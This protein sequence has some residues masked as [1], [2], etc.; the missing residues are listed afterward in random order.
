MVNDEMRKLGKTGDPKATKYL[1]LHGVWKIMF[2]KI[3]DKH[4]SP[5]Y[6]FTHLMGSHFV[7]TRTFLLA[8]ISTL[9]LEGE[10]PGIPGAFTA[11]QQVR[12]DP[13]SAGKLA[14]IR[15]SD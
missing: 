8:P 10:G 2:W 3:I 14:N 9:E 13:E 12:L 7:L 15:V 6:L 1:T 11:T 5:A 4:P